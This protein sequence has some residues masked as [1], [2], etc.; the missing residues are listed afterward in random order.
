MQQPLLDIRNLSIDLR[1]A[2]GRSTRLVD[3]LSL[4][5]LPG[6]T[7]GIV[8]ESGCGKSITA[9]ATMQLLSYPLFVSGGRILFGGDDLL[10]FGK[11]QMQKIRGRRIS[12]IF[13]EPMTSLD[14]IFTVENQLIEIL[15]IHFKDMPHS[16]M[17]A[18]IT[19]TL[20]KVGIARIEQ[21]LQS[22]PHQ[23]SGGML[24]RIM[25]A[26]ALICDPALLI[27]DEPTTA[28]DVTIQA[29]I[30]ALMNELKDNFDTSVII[31][32]HDLG[33]VAETCQRVAVLYAGQ[34]VEQATASELFHHPAHPYTQGLLRSVTALGT[35]KT[36]YSI[37]GMVPAMEDLGSGCRF[38]ERCECAKDICKAPQKLE[39]IAPGHVCRCLRAKEGEL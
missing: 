1:R 13:Q 5:M 33:V 22:Y 12:M 32:T 30:L 20:K 17:I 39:E 28:L 19:D 31:I 25:I 11:R 29:Q 35:E 3:D 14:P 4:T 27:A 23:L 2:R 7:F 6:E 18:K 9:L 38:F 34:V 36:L 37:R 15:R 16:D 21:V 24:Q 8:G 26:M 10:L